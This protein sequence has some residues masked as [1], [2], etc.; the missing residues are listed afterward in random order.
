MT[1]L[2][3]DQTIS[4]GGS[5]CPGCGL[6]FTVDEDFYYNSAHYTKDECPECGKKFSVEVCHSVS[7]ICTLIPDPTTPPKREET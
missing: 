6:M 5:Q 4:D 2:R 7:W 3:D 1:K